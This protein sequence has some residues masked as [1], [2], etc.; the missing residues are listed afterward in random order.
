MDVE[1][2]APS[3]TKGVIVS[4][5]QDVGNSVANEREGRSKP[6]DQAEA[7]RA[8]P[9]G[10]KTP[11]VRDSQRPRPQDA[12]DQTSKTI[13]TEDHST[14][15]AGDSHKSSKRNGGDVTGNAR[16]Q[17][18]IQQSTGRIGMSA[19]QLAAARAAALP[20][21]NVR[22]M[23][24]AINPP[25]VNASE[26]QKQTFLTNILSRS[27]SPSNARALKGHPRATLVRERREQAIQTP[28][29][30]P[31]TPRVP[32]PGNGSQDQRLAF[33]LVFK[34]KEREKEITNLRLEIQKLEQQNESL[35]R[36]NA[37]LVE[38]KGEALRQNAQILQQKKAAISKAKDLILAS[39]ET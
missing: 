30:T 29:R 24:N 34:A 23:N 12:K 4:N 31:R 1:V 21:L 15:T 9:E 13:R 26:E 20:P 5:A 17:Q 10:K 6:H 19:E 25:F 2:E 38:E 28:Q 27:S 37:G 39:Q 18:K 33:D 11:L 35:E 8:E 36:L 22:S 3:V 16:F 14:K 32:I 7:P